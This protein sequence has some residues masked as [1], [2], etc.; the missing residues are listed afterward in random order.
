MGG[1]KHSEAGP[2]PDERRPGGHR[3]RTRVTTSGSA[4]RPIPSAPHSAAALSPNKALSA[5]TDDAYV[6][7]QSASIGP[8]GPSE[9]DPTM[10]YP[11]SDTTVDTRSQPSRLV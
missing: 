7:R 1:A 4:T 3:R 11:A 9:R 10:H 5:R 8:S 6:Q 2:D